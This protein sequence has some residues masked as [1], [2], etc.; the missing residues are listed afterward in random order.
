MYQCLSLQEN[1][2]T[3][4]L[5]GKSLAPGTVNP[6][7]AALPE[8]TNSNP[9]KA[10]GSETSPGVEYLLM[11][12]YFAHYFTLSFSFDLALLFALRKMYSLIKF[13]IGLKHL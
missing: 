9:Y 11:L 8:L 3:E 4:Y 5:L 6:S 1:L 7:P 13:S 10:T 2:V 12:L